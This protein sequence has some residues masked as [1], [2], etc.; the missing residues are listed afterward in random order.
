M[1]D[2]TPIICDD[3]LSYTAVASASITGGQV[4]VV[5]GVNTVGPA[6]VAALP[7]AGVASRDAVSGDNLTVYRSG[8]Q[9]LVATGTVAAGD[10]LTS[11]ASGTVVTNAAPAAGTHIGTAQ[12]AA[13]AGNKVRVIFNR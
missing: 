6:G 2:Y 12:T 13:T 8:I 9:N 5:T 3:D 4:L 11:G 7:I 10:A 1:A